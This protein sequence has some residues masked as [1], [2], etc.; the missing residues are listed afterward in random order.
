MKATP[1]TSKDYKVINTSTPNPLEGTVCASLLMKRKAYM[2]N[3]PG[4][5]IAVC[6]QVDLEP[7]ALTRETTLPRGNAHLLGRSTTQLDSKAAGLR[8]PGSQQTRHHQLCWLS[9]I[10]SPGHT[11]QLNLCSINDSHCLCDFFF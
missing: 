5:S 2:S 7:A 4:F 9:L 8:A 10:C 1:Q 3:R 11:A 6:E